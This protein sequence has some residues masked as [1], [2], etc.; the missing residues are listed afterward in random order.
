M[1]KMANVGSD[2][3]LK[4]HR[5]LPI[6]IPILVLSLA[7]LI[8]ILVPKSPPPPNQL[9]FEDSNVQEDTSPEVIVIYGDN[10]TNYEIHQ[11]I[12]N[13]IL[14]LA[15]VMVFNTG[16]LV[17][18]GNN[19][20]QWEI[21]NEITYT[22]RNES[23]FY[24]AIGNHERNSDLYYENFELPNNEQWY[25]VDYDS[26]HFVVLDSNVD[27]STTSEQYIWLERDL[28]ANA[29]QAD[30]LVAIFH[31]P[32]FTV[33]KHSEASELQTTIVP[34]FEKYGVDIAFNG[35]DH[36]YQRNF[37]NDVYYIVTGGGGAPLYD[38]TTEKSY[39]QKFVKSYHFCTLEIEDINMIVKAF[40][41]NSNLID[42]FTIEEK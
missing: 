4:Q 33:G 25:T 17:E 26:I 27:I 11:Q 5:L 8:Y 34:L 13:E 1:F 37:V 24:P 31:H 22:L 40:D 16:D 38:Q 42:E 28:E 12:V 21:F 18:D 3:N 7:L 30:F 29:S 15:P 36:N 9:Y 14:K 20:T 32:P 41:E 6:L 23:E 10:R 19:A 39:N 35:H 2:K